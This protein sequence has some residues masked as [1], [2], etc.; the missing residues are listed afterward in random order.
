MCCNRAGETAAAV[1]SGV[2]VSEGGQRRKLLGVRRGTGSLLSKSRKAVLQ[3]GGKV[4]KLFCART[5]AWGYLNLS[6]SF[7]LFCVA[8]LLLCL[9][10]LGREEKLSFPETLSNG[11][12]SVTDLVMLSPLFLCAP[13]ADCGCHVTCS[14]NS[15]FIFRVEVSP[16]LLQYEYLGKSTGNWLDIGSYWPLGLSQ[17]FFFP[18]YLSHY[19]AGKILESELIL[20]H[21][22]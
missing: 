16:G 2:W 22:I 4:S 17:F 12:A 14:W 3:G 5:A 1:V 19:N 20:W 7:S 8:L 21:V 9:D 18:L 13:T 6:W 15:F 11:T 10:G